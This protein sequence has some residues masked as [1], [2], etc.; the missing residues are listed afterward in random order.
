M[1]RLTV[2]IIFDALEQGEA[3]QSFQHG[4]ARIRQT[5]ANPLFPC[6]L[7]LTFSPRGGEG[8]TN[9][10]PPPR[11]NPVLP[12]SSL[13]REPNV[14]PSPLRGEGQGEGI[15]P[16]LYL[17]TFGGEGKASDELSPNGRSGGK[18]PDLSPPPFGERV[19][20][21]GTP[22]SSPSPPQGE[23]GQQTTGFPPP[24]RRDNERWTFPR[25]GKKKRAVNVPQAGKGAAND[26]I[27]SL[28]PLGRESNVFPSP[29]WGE[30]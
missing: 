28:A 22:S 11:E 6:P 19:R 14:F 17:F 30:G 12:L 4:T 10:S 25:G 3:L 26:R 9:D 5:P 1:K 23:K 29:R 8:T 21:R 24:R 16:H 7:I 15:S 13:G 27:F 20:V 2:A 18:R